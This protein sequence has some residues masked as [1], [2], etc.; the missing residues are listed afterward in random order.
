MPPRPPVS[1]VALVRLVVRNCSTECAGESNAMIMHFQIIASVNSTNSSVINLRT[2]GSLF[3]SALRSQSER[4]GFFVAQGADAQIPGPD[5]RYTDT[6]A[7]L[8]TMYMNLDR[9][10]IEEY[11][12]GKFWNVYNEWLPLDTLALGG[13]LLEWGHVSEAQEYIGAFLQAHVDSSGTLNYS[14]FGCDSDADY[15]RL[16]SLYSQLTMY[17]NNSGSWPA[18]MLPIIHRMASRA[19]QLRSAAVADFPTTDPR[20]GM[21]PGSP[22]HD[23]CHETGYFFSVNVWFARG[24]LDLHRVHLA[25]PAL[26]LNRTL[27]DALLPTVTAWRSD[28]HS[29]ATFTVVRN[30][31]PS[32]A[33]PG[34]FYFLH[35]LV[36]SQGGVNRVTTLLPGGTSADC[37]ERG[38]CFYSMTAPLPNGGS[39]QITNYANF[40][41]F[42]ETLLAGVLAPEYELAIMSYREQHRGT[43]LGMTR[44]RDVLDDMPILGYGRGALRGD[45]V[46]SFH[47]TLAGHALNYLTRG[48]YWGTEQRQQLEWIGPYRNDCSIGGEDCSLCMVSSVATAYWIRWMLVVEDVL[49]DVLYVARGAPRRWYSAIDSF[50][51]TAA[52]TRFGSC[53]F[54]IN[55]SPTALAG[56]FKLLRNAVSSSNNITVAVRLRSNDAITPFRC[57]RVT[58]GGA[59]LVNWFSGNETAVFSIGGTVAFFNFSASSSCP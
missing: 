37:G 2:N 56:S 3:Y 13:A 35:P 28:I 45:R 32:S 38:T 51:I 40:R 24:L 59:T 6:A 58:A 9:G 19:L 14:V 18:T 20:H 25:F 47:A 16:I 4:Y 53:T 12:G 27:E 49:D 17:S 55:P 39:N 41:I 15:G 48:T 5:R 10:D 29:A 22:E 44:F 57:A 54:Q 46:P 33:S 50:G 26:S 1:V 30:V 52:P 31:Q 43:L 21:V 8:L 34:P 7:A 42:S 36:G 23:I 11:G